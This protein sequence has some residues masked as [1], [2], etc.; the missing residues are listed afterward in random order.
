MKDYNADRKR[1]RR[2]PLVT[3]GGV[4]KESFKLR[5]NGRIPKS[6]RCEDSLLFLHPLMP[7]TPRYPIGT[8][9]STGY[10]RNQNFKEGTS[11]SSD[12]IKAATDGSKAQPVFSPSTNWYQR[13]NN[14]G[15]R[16]FLTRDPKK[17]VPKNQKVLDRQQK[18]KNN[19]TK[20]YMKDW[21]HF[22]YLNMHGSSIIK[23]LRTELAESHST[24]T[25]LKLHKHWNKSHRRKVGTCACTKPG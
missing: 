25:A 21:A 14:C 12:G 10:C 23:T 19:L 9:I 2:S 4:R 7:Q 11:F 22:S 20:F 17:G 1:C 18:G 16:W 5:E 24:A 3:A 13:W 15:S 6:V 8:L